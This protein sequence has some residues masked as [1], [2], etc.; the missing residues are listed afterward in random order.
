M[1]SFAARAL[2]LVLALALAGCTV[3]RVDRV[4]TRDQRITDPDYT[5]FYRVMGERF[6]ED[7]RY[8][9]AWTEFAALGDFEALSR[10]LMAF[11]ADGDKFSEPV[12]D[13]MLTEYARG[14]KRQADT[15]T[16][17][18]ALV[19]PLTEISDEQLA[20]GRARQ[21]WVIR[22]RLLARSEQLIDRKRYYPQCVSLLAALR[23]DPARAAE[24]ERAAAELEA[25]NDAHMGHLAPGTE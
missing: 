12:Y 23:E 17:L 6:L 7:R 1:P 5:G 25:I 22:V 3:T 18:Q 8:T 20:Q 24:A 16:P 13:S 14:L 10:V 21:A 2:T 11:A 19:E 15:R 4:S 9:D